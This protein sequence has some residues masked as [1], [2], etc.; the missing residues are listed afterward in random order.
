MIDRRAPSRLLHLEPLKLPLYKQEIVRGKEGP[1]LGCGLGDNRE[2][3][4][5]KPKAATA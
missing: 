4:A 2:A 3:R 5:V 1:R